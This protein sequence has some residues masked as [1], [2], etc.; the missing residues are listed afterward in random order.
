[1]GPLD[2]FYSKSPSSACDICIEGLT[3]TGDNHSFADKL[4][5]I[6]PMLH[7]LKPRKQRA[8]SFTSSLQLQFL[9]ESFSFGFTEQ[10]MLL[11]MGGLRGLECLEQ[12]Y[13]LAFTGS[14]LRLIVGTGF[15]AKP[16]R[17][18]SHKG[19]P[20]FLFYFITQIFYMLV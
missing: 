5:Q 8:A 17:T 13:G 3:G 19:L 20:L 6:I 18:D 1:M 12:N 15:I 10:L 14:S 7:C 11:K 2:K 16:S 9:W 4:W